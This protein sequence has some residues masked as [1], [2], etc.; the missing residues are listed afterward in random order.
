[1]TPIYKKLQKKWNK[2]FSR[3]KEDIKD[4]QCMFADTKEG[5]HSF[6]LPG[7]LGCKFKHDILAE[8]SAIEVI[9]SHTI[10]SS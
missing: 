10:L 8:K 6:G 1:M 9:L 3:A 5:C 4:V 2:I 7:D